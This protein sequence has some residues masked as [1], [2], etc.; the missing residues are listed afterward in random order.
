MAEV[1]NAHG[2]AAGLRWSLVRNDVTEI[3]YR[4]GGFF[5][6]HQDFLSVQ[7]NVIE[8]TIREAITG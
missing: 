4:A 3:R 5:K 1:N 7:G 8:E 6:R 2:A